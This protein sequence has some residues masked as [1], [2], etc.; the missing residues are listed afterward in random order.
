MRPLSARPSIPGE[1]ARGTSEFSMGQA[2]SST[3]SVVTE[4][5]RMPYSLA[6]RNEQKSYFFNRKQP[7]NFNGAAASRFPEF[8]H[9]GIV[10]VFFGSSLDVTISFASRGCR[11]ERHSQLIGQVER[12]SKIL[13]HEPQRKTWHVLA[14]KKI[15]RFNVQQTGAPHAGLQNL[16]KFFA[17]NSRSGG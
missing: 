15:R 12:E 17:L 7:G 1:D 4:S 14:L 10:Q 2:R 3:S 9:G 5:N 11:G 16:H 13:V 6:E 8:H